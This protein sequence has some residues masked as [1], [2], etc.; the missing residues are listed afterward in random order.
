MTL[1]ED[2]I[3]RQRAEE[4]LRKL[5]RAVE[6]SGSMIFITD[7]SGNIE[8]VNPAFSK[9][10][11]Y[12]PEEAIG[13]NPSMIKSGKMSPE[14]YEELWTTISRGEVWEGELLN[15]K[16][17]GE[18]YWEFA[19][20]SPVKDKDGKIT[21]YLAVKEDITDRKLAEELLKESHQKLQEVN[22]R[23]AIIY[24]IG[25]AITTQLQ[26]ETVL[27][28]LAQ[29]IAKLLGTDTSAILLTD[30]TTQTLC[31]KS[32]YGLSENLVKN[33]SF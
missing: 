14:T 18:L 16:K 3:K 26:L 8:F 6:Q 31:I 5:S 4:E 19:N 2:I 24:E 9:I 21:H 30:E 33:K 10:T 29:S 28:I 22:E 15:R 13:Q 23:L 11:G 17:N 25:R 1:R 7:L 32:S 12:S 27:D 20:I